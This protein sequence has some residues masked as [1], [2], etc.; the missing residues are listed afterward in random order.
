MVHNFNENDNV[1][2]KDAHSVPQT[3]MFYGFWSSCRLWGVDLSKSLFCKI[4]WDIYHLHAVFCNY[5]QTCKIQFGNACRQWLP[6]SVSLSEE[7]WEDGGVAF[8]TESTGTK[9]C[10][11]PGS[12][13]ELKL[14]EHPR[15][16]GWHHESLNENILLG[17]L[18]LPVCLI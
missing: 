4:V 8:F 17:E 18:L 16:A 1:F 15:R 2:I 5:H 3:C 13:C 6:S 9:S 11:L 7:G 12:P 14:A 10:M